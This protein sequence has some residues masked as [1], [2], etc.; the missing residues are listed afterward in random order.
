MPFKSEKQ[1]RWMYA[2]KPEM[3]AKWEKEEKKREEDE[4]EEEQLTEKALRQIIR[5]VL[6]AEIK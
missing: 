4:V 2:N 1:R 3:A 5:R 6:L